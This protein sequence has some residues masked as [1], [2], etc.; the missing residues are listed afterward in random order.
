MAH[1]DQEWHGNTA[2]LFEDASARGRVGCLITRAV[3]GEEQYELYRVH[4]GDVSP[5]ELWPATRQ[6][7]RS[8]ATGTYRRY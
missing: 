4:F 5:C 7:S 3:L 8:A 6:A 2:P 1:R